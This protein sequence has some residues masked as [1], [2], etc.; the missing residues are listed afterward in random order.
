MNMKDEFIKSVQEAYENHPEY[1]TEQAIEYFT[2]LKNVVEEQKEEF[3]ENGKTILRYL[4]TSDKEMWKA[5][6]IADDIEISSRSVSGS[7]RKLVADGYAE[8]T[9][10]NP[11]VYTLTS[12]GKEK[13]L[14]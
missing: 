6:D 11:V 2:N 14:D 4:Q 13:V 8:K 12:K 5:K 9:G 1:F 10:K 3:T 7:M